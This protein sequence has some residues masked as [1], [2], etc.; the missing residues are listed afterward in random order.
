MSGR[1]YIGPFLSQ[2][3]GSSADISLHGQTAAIA[4]TAILGANAP[5][6]FWR[7]NLW[8]TTE[9][10]GTAGTLTLSLS[11]TQGGTDSVGNFF[12]PAVPVPGF[13][14]AA[15]QFVFQS[16]GTA[17]IFYTVAFTGVTVGALQYGVRVTLEQLSN[18]A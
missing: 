2:P 1:K 9:V 11:A 16:N 18:L 8:I 17:D 15:G 4:P 3:I 10:A 14:N 12:L 13:G 5:T 6:G 7:A